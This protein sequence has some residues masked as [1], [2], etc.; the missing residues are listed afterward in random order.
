MNS[1]A[2]SFSTDNADR[3]YRLSVT[4]AEKLRCINEAAQRD[5]KAA[6]WSLERDPLSREEFSNRNRDLEMPKI[7]LNIHRDEV[8]ID[9]QKGR[10]DCIEG[11]AETVFEE[12]EE[13]TDED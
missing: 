10:D 8:V 11:E 3:G 6:A 13:V 5:W 9:G 12:D 7:I 4:E 1:H 2:D